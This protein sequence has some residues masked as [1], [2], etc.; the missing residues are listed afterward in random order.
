[1]LI[2]QEVDDDTPLQW[3]AIAYYYPNNITPVVQYF[4]TEAT[5]ER[6][7]RQLNANLRTGA[8]TDGQ[9]SFIEE[10]YV[11]RTTK[12]LFDENQ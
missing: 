7:L 4:P 10:A 1:M 11:C 5:A 12:E 8:E 3:A 2:S 9:P 6:W